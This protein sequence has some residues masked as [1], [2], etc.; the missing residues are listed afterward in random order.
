MVY[1]GRVLDH[2]SPTAPSRSLMTIPPWSGLSPQHSPWPEGCLYTG[3]PQTH[4]ESTHTA[5]SHVLFC[6]PYRPRLQPE[7]A[8][9][10]EEEECVK[11]YHSRDTQ[12]MPH[13]LSQGLDGPWRIKR[14]KDF[15]LKANN[16]ACAPNFT[17]SQ[18]HPPSLKTKQNTVKK[19]F[20][21]YK[22]TRTLRTGEDVIPT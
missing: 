11:I 21:E 8:W 4:S 10:I 14:Q 22:S 7:F 3:Q 9:L 16:W 5:M 18:I 15:K 17:S 2:W 1:N 13:L 12:H 20:K 6:V 19:Y